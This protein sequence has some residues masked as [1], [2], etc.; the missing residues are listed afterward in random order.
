M[1]ETGFVE[2][3]SQHQLALLTSFKGETKE[4]LHSGKVCSDTASDGAIRHMCDTLGN[5]D[6]HVSVVMFTVTLNRISETPV[7][8]CLS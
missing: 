1:I 5:A 2:E 3:D 8:H 6:E 7:L 4:T